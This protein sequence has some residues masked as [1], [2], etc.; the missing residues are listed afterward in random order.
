MNEEMNCC[1]TLVSHR[2]LE[3]SLVIHLLEHPNWVKG[4]VI[5]QGEG[6]S[7]KEMLPSIL[8]QVRGRSQRV[9]FQSVMSLE[10]AR[11][12]VNHLKEAEGNAEIVYWITPV[13]DFGRMG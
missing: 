12:L 1:L 4:F 7:Q 3:E 9:S 8:E 11:A 5:L 6:T 2:S 10:N 13:L